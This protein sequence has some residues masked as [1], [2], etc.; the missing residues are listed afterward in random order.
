M[1]IAAARGSALMVAVVLLM[2]VSAIGLG[3]VLTTSL[4]PAMAA[5]SESSLVALYGAEAGVTAAAAELSGIADWEGVLTGMRR[6]SVLDGNPNARLALPDGTAA[7]LRALTNMLTC[8]HVEACT[9]GE[10]DAFTTDRP[11]GPNNPRWQLFGAA[12][13]DGL[14]AGVTGIAP[15]AIVVWV[16]D[17]PAE[18]DGNPLRDR[19]LLPNGSPGP[20]SGLLLVRADGFAAR[21]ARRTVLATVAR[22]RWNGD[23]RRPVVAWREV[24]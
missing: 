6:S 7:D 5:A 23:P 13:L 16:A 1:C 20:G 11:W 22:P 14:L 18:T 15:C 3:L 2:L 12:R 8:G 17:D 21:S 10:M 19:G 9:G 24:R 4:E